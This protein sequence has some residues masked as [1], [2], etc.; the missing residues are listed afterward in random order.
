[1]WVLWILLGPFGTWGGGVRWCIQYDQR[2][3]Y[4]IYIYKHV[5]NIFIERERYS[6][7]SVP[8]IVHHLG[9]LH[10]GHIVSLGGFL[11]Q[12]QVY[13]GVLLILLIF[14]YCRWQC[15]KYWILEWSIHYFACYHYFTIC[16]INPASQP[17]SSKDFRVPFRVR[18]PCLILH[19]AAV[20]EIETKE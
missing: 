13:D 19:D 3:G 10:I 15:S 4:D 17:N 20:P 18:T 1:M 14:T 11:K 6:R 16:S 5:Y 9:N 7:T 12:I 2:T 8:N